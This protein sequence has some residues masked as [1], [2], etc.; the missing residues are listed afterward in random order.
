MSLRRFK[1]ITRSLVVFLAVGTTFGFGQ[2]VQVTHDVVP[3]VPGAGYDYVKSL[4]E[5]VDPQMGTLQVRVGLPMPAGRDMT[6]PFAFAYNSNLALHY[7]T[8]MGGQPVFNWTDNGSYLGRSGW[9]YVVPSLSLFSGSYFVG[10]NGGPPGP[11]GNLKCV[12]FADYSFTDEQGT[13][14]DMRNAGASAGMGTSDPSPA[15]QG[16]GAPNMGIT[17]LSATDGTYSAST[18]QLASGQTSPPPVTV[19]DNDGTLYQFSNPFHYYPGDNQNNVSLGGFSAN[20][21]ATLPS[22]IETRNGNQI[23]ITDQGKGIFSITDQLGRSVLSTNGFGGTGGTASDT[24]NVSGFGA[25]SATWSAPQSFNWPNNSET[26]LVSPGPDLGHCGPPLTNATGSQPVITQIT[27]ANSQSFQFAY[28]S[29]TGLLSQITYPNGALVSYT[30]T[31]NPLS[32]SNTYA[33]PPSTGSPSNITSICSLLHDTPAVQTRI[34]KFDGV[35][36]ALEQDFSYSTTWGPI[37]PTTGL[38][39]WTTKQ[40]TVTT[41]DLVRGTSFHTVYTYTQPVLLSITNFAS[42]ASTTVYSTVDNLQG[43]G[44]SLLRT[45]TKSWSYFTNPP[46]TE[47]VALDNGQTS[48]VVSCYPIFTAPAPCPSVNVNSLLAILTDRY[49]YGFGPGLPGPLLRHTHY[50]YQAFPANPLGIPIVDRPAHEII[51][52]ANNN[53]VAET[54]YAYDQQTSLASASATKHDDQNFSTTLVAGRGNVTTKTE[55]CFTGSGSSQRAC[56]QGNSVTTHTYDQTGQMLSKTDPNGNITKYSYSDSF[57]DSTPSSSTNAYLTQITY[58]PTNGVNH[59]VNFSYALSDGQLTASLDQNKQ[60]TTYTYNDPLRRLTQTKFPDFGQTSVSYNDAGPNPSVVTTTTITSSMNLISTVVMDGMGHAVQTQLNSDPAGVDFTDTTYDGLGRIR[61]VNNPH[62]GTGLP[63]DGVTQNRYD[64]LNRITDVI[65]QD[66]SIVHTVYKGN[67]TAVIDETGRLRRTVSDALGRLVE[68]DEPPA[69]SSVSSPGAVARSAGAISGNEQFVLTPASNFSFSAAPSSQTASQGASTSFI[70]SIAPPSG[71]TDTMNLSVSGLPQGAT[72]SFS[73]TLVSGSGSSTLTITVGGSTQTGSYNLTITGDSPSY[74]ATATVTLAVTIN[75]AVLMAIINNI[76]LSDSPTSASTAPT[77]KSS[78]LAS[79]STSAVKASGPNGVPPVGRPL[80]PPPTPRAGATAAAPAPAANTAA[81]SQPSAVYFKSFDAGSVWI[82]VQGFTATARYGQGSTASSV[83]DDL[84][85]QFNNPNSGSP[86]GAFVT[87][88]NLS[89]FATGGNYTIDAQGS[90]SDLSGTFSQPSFAVSMPGLSGGADPTANSTGTSGSSSISISGSLAS[91]PGSYA[92]GSF[93]VSGKDRATHQICVDACEAPSPQ[94]G[95]SGPLIWDAGSVTLSINGVQATADYGQFSTAG[96]LADS[97]VSP[98]SP[99]PVTVTSNDGNGNVQVMADT[100]GPNYSLSATSDTDDANDFGAGTTSFPVQVSGAT[101]TGG[102]YPIYDSG[103]LT[104]TVNG[105]QASAPY[106][107]NLNNSASAMAQALTNALN[108]AGSPVTASVSGTTITITATDVGAGTNY[109]VSGSSTASF[110]ASSTTLSGGT[111]LGGSSPPYVTLYSYDAL[112]NLL[113]VNQQGDG[114]QPARV[115]TFTYDSLSHLLTAT[116]PES[117]TLTYGYDATGNVT[118]KTDARGVIINYNPSDSRIDALN[119]VTKKTFSNGQTAVRYSYDQGANGIGHLTGVTDPAGSGSY[120]YDAMGRISSE[121]RTIA[122]VTKSLS[123][124]YNLDNSI[125][126]AT[127]PSGAKI[128]YTP[129]AAGTMVSAVDSGNS[130]NYVTQ[131]TYAPD[132]SLTGF[133]SGGTITNSFSYNNRLQPLTMEASTPQ[134]KVFGLKYDFQEGN[135]DNGN[136]F[137]IANN[138]DDTRSQSFTY[139]VL[140]RLSSAQNAGIDCTQGALNSSKFWGNS[141]GYDPWGNLLTKTV[142]K[143]QSENLNAYADA[144]NR[145]HV[146]SGPDFQYDAAGNMTYNVAGPLAPQSYSYDAENRITG[147]GSFAYT[148]DADGNRV[149]KSNGSTGTIYWY[150][151]PGIVAESDLSGNLQSEYVFFNGER[152]ARKDF[153]S[154]AVS[155]YFSDHLKTASVITDSAGNIK[156]DEDYFPYGGEVKFVD[157]D[158]NHYKFTGKER[159]TE[160]GLDLMGARYY[161]NSLGRFVTPDPLVM[162]LHRLADPQSLNLYHYAR[163]N[164]LSYADETGLDVNLDCSKVSSAQC[165][166]TV[167]DLNNRKDAQFQVTR[168]DKTGLLQAKVDD[169]STL[170]KSEGELYKAINDT[171][172]HATLELRAFSPNIMGDQYVKPGFNVLDRADLTQFG[173]ANSALPGEIIAHA[174]VE[175]YAGVAEGKTN[176]LDAHNFASQFFGKL[177]YTDPVGLPPGAAKSTSGVSTYS[178]ERLGT[179]VNVQKIFITAQPSESVPKN[180][181]R[182]PGNLIVSTTDKKK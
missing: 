104:V 70:I 26:T 131:A 136:V 98:L 148:Y 106:N 76:L 6:L 167:T 170:S 169:P 143:C 79:S 27:L 7:V 154:N 20:T 85:S 29:V 151:S 152:V 168:D 84:A 3:P 60:K 107:Q 12:F 139:D 86:V 55:K 144:Q 89:L 182:I 51:Y 166:Q 88:A 82:T 110:T 21:P 165:N 31:A 119:R 11:G 173:K 36:A 28:D 93:S 54:D 16:P 58:P 112:G 59:I 13:Q 160:T 39:K 24:I 155:Y 73:P 108:V 83:A 128:T 38:R 66:G 125:S 116:N 22:L 162:E 113:S 42:N 177:H 65:K 90:K 117:G 78:S 52:D 178:F 129:D 4:A 63:T 163:N 68:V 109:T 124:I 103:T 123:Y 67:V 61:S 153:P 158:P 37:E 122:G 157:N 87:G 1:D 50:D 14:R 134:Q 10:P 72:Y 91:K 40:T 46:T 47:T 77:T 9:R 121:Q 174:A 115:R 100:P 175:A 135:G 25:Y 30:W 23:T 137:A 147:A 80:A 176:Y 99:H 5:T 15:C 102:V 118:S 74:S 45:T 71:D 138:R 57:S 145:L 132:S 48:E 33:V 17:G 32:A 164:P 95:P 127:Y 126:T 172:N 141:Y 34:V 179:S 92:T 49:E 140:N 53:V 8:V 69:G 64:S 19:M 159:D 101:L 44:G 43:T 114:S 97:L 35:H 180:W 75:P 41:K 56:P 133:V 111:D 146:I 2:V 105:F 62:R 120:S 181:E 18:S 149:E 142:T 156:E 150:M 171:N 94:I 81:G 130:I 96:D 161:L